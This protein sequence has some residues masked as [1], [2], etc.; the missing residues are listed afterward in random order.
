MLSTAAPVEAMPGLPSTTVSVFVLGVTVEMTGAEL[1]AGAGPRRLAKHIEEPVMPVSVMVTTVGAVL[2]AVT[3]TLTDAKPLVP[4]GV[5][6]TLA[7]PDEPAPKAPP[8][9]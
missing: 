7:L 6:V 5:T 9:A 3:V 2:A 8:T 1:V 4:P